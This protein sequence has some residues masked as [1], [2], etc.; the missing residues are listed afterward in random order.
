MEDVF[1]E[2]TAVSST[3]PSAAT[4]AT[5]VAAASTSQSATPQEK[6]KRPPVRKRFRWNDEIRFAPAV[7]V[8][9]AHACICTCTCRK[10]LC[11]V[12]KVKITC[13]EAS[14]AGMG[15]VKADWEEIIGVSRTL[16][17]SKI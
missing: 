10:L 3:L 15:G 12:V 2:S 9:P 13:E 8:L 11:A 4:A 6:I 17:A 7:C 5:A 1:D 14:R 16:K